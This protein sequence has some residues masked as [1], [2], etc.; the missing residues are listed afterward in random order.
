[1]NKKIPFDGAFCCQAENNLYPEVK[2]INTFLTHLAKSISRQ[3]FL[4]L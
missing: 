3:L 1:M 2:F 4:Y